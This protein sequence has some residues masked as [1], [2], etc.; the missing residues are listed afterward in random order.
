MI[1]ALMNIQGILDE[2]KE[3]FCLKFSIRSV[4]KLILSE[5]GTVE[6]ENIDCSRGNSSLIYITIHF[7]L[8]SNSL[9]YQ[10]GRD[11]GRKRE[12]ES[13]RK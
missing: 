3:S 6:K 13:R 7:I 5:K 8:S 11:R 2:L 12:G 10:G 1:G 4:V 9:D